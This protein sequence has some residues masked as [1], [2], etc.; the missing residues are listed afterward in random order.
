[1]RVLIAI[2]LMC[3]AGA[4]A[5]RSWLFLSVGLALI[6]LVAIAKGKGDPV[7]NFMAGLAFIIVIGAV[8]GLAKSFT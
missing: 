3:L 1:M 5:V 4:L 8:V 7:E 2:I 6:A